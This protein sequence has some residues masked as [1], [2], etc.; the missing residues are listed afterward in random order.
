[1]NFAPKIRLIDS[2]LKPD[3]QADKML[4]KMNGFTYGQR[5]FALDGGQLGS[6]EQFDFLQGALPNQ[7]TNQ[8]PRHTFH[9]C[10]PVGDIKFQKCSKTH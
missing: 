4:M 9:H 2:S 10:V 8:S 5:V 6:V 7:E 1:L 3:P